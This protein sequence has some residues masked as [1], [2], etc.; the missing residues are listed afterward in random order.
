LIK[1]NVV[2]VFIPPPVDPGE[3][4]MNIK[5]IIINKPAFVKFPNGYVL[6]PAVLAEVL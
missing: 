3:A 2:V 1:V 6:K 4:P 5:I